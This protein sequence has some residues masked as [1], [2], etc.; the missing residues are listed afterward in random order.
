MFEQLPI[1]EKTYQIIRW[2]YPTINK[3]PKSQRFVL[4]Q[5]IENTALLILTGIIAANGER[6]KVPA[7]KRVSTLLDTLR[8]L[9]RLSKDLGFISVKQYVFAAERVNEIGKMLGGWMKQS[10][11][12]APTPV[13][14]QGRV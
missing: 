2:L 8:I 9:I 4:G 11:S 1:F 12:S 5:Q 13:R 14:G 3:F 6:D 7:L 10:A